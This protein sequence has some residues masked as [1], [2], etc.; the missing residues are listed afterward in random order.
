MKLSSNSFRAC[1]PIIFLS[2]ATMASAVSFK[3]FETIT[4]SI[5][6]SHDNS[7]SITTGATEWASLLGKLARIKSIS[8]DKNEYPADFEW[9]ESSWI[10]I[11]KIKNDVQ[12][13]TAA[14][15]FF[16]TIDGLVRAYHAPINKTWN[17]NV[18]RA[19]FQQAIK[20]TRPVDES[21]I[22]QGYNISIRDICPDG[23]YV[24]GIMGEVTAMRLIANSFKASCDV[25][26]TSNNVTTHYSSSG[27]TGGAVYSGTSGGRVTFPTSGTGTGTKTSTNQTSLPNPGSIVG[28]SIATTNQS[29]YS[30]GSVNSVSPGNLVNTPL[31]YEGGSSVSRP[32]IVATKVTPPSSAQP[33]HST[34]PSS[35]P[36][37]PTSSHIPEA[38]PVVIGL[39]LGGIGM[40]FFISILVSMVLSFFGLLYYI[41]KTAKKNLTSPAPITVVMEQSIISAEHV[42][43]PT[44]HED[45]VLLARQGKYDHAIRLLT[46]GSMLLLD[47]RRVLNFQNSITNGEYL[48][49]LIEC[50]HEELQSLWRIPLNL[51]D[52]L[53]YGFKVPGWDEFAVFETL[54]LKLRDM[55]GI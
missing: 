5:Q 30:G 47:E 45:A 42:H 49:N 29:G 16:D 38:V 2:V 28:S 40:I 20:D 41:F 22:A 35:P 32:N 33:F 27:S 50:E 48:R 21:I 44:L 6:T 52:N 25:K 31:T 8:I 43:I 39:G 4:E 18:I 26:E 14:E 7:G 24:Q 15:A 23:Y 46:V 3:A 55:K 34:P 53:I 36:S 10:E 51:F 54:Y 17:P 12:R 13:R 1:L 37:Y 9:V 11:S 19:N